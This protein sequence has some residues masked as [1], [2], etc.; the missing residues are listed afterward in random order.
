MVVLPTAMQVVA[1]FPAPDNLAMRAILRPIVLVTFLF[2][3]SAPCGGCSTIAGTAVS[4]ITGGVDLVR[5]YLSPKAMGGRGQAWATP[6]VFLGG[7]IAGPFVALYN[8]VNHDVTVFRNFR[9]YWVEFGDVF[10]PFHMV[11]EAAGER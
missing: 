11:N 7:V 9:R 8:G 4:P 10:R 6:F 3:I 1:A 5:E 2:G